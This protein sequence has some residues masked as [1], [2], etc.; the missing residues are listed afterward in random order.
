[1]PVWPKKEEDEGRSSRMKEEEGIGTS[2]WN[3][4]GRQNQPGLDVGRGREGRGKDDSRREGRSG[5]GRKI[6]ISTL[7]TLSLKF[8]GDSRPRAPAD[9]R[10]YRF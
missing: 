3:V 1:M 4:F 2:L 8:Y 6:L 10:I 5:S 7:D 9:S